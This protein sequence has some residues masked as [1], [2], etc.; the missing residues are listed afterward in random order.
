MKL[1]SDPVPTRTQRHQ[2][3]VHTLAVALRTVEIYAPENSTVHRVVAD[4][5]GALLPDGSPTGV[6]ILAMRNHCLF[7]DDERVRFGPSDYPNSR[8]IMDTFTSWSIGSLAFL[9]GLTG[10]EVRALLYAFDARADERGLE[11]LADRLEELGVEHVAVGGPA[12]EHSGEVGDDAPSPVEPQLPTAPAAAGEESVGR[13]GGPSLGDD[14]VPKWAQPFTENRSVPALRTYSACLD[15]CRELQEAVR[16]M[17]QLGTRRLR[18]VT[19]SVVDQVLRDDGAILAMTTIKEFDDYLFTHSSNVAIL[20]VALG[21][22]VGYDRLRLGELCLAAFLHD[23]GK[24]ELPRE[25]LD[26]ADALNAQEW[27]LMREHPVA[28]VNILLEQEQ[29]SPSTLRAIVELASST[30]STTT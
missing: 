27:D 28:S 14:S 6:Q 19:Q 10:H 3:L 24:T 12:G 8:Y 16:G 26:K 7:V 20:A 21:Q 18:R 11:F 2:Q 30:T 9:P 17:K 4:L 15:V 25:L 29:L 13:Q 23:L 22:R 1:T 5:C